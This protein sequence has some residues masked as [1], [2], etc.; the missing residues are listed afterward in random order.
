MLGALKQVLSLGLN[1]V[2]FV[3][4]HHT[5]LTVQ[6]VPAV[7]IRCSACIYSTVGTVLEYICCVL[8]KL[9]SGVSICGYFF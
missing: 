3:L 7:G 2:R 8:A 1:I 9:S 4:R 5:L 6:Y